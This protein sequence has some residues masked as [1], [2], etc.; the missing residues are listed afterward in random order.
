MLAFCRFE[1]LFAYLTT[2]IHLSYCTILRGTCTS[3]KARLYSNQ[4]S[5]T[6]RTPIK[7]FTP[8]LC[9]GCPF[10][11]RQ[12]PTHQLPAFHSKT[13][14]CCNVVLLC[15]CLDNMHENRKLYIQQIQRFVRTV[16]NTQWHFVCMC[17][18]YQT[19]H[20]PI[21]IQLFQNEN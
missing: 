16:P 7:A 13:L 2:T 5:Q 18:V 17:N 1:Y 11:G 19:K 10:P 21:N 3:R 20:G 15:A 14:Q 8:S 6:I 9:K 4:Y 12:P